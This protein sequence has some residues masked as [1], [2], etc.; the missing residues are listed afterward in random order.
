MAH[1]DDVIRGNVRKWVEAPVMYNGGMLDGKFCV[2]MGSSPRFDMYGCE[3]GWG[4]AVALRSGA[5]SKFEGKVSSYPGWE[6]GGSV[7]LEVCLSTEA[8]TAL[9]ADPE[10]LNVVSLNIN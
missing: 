2:L 6:G 5:A 7:D 1:T 4:K 3:F 9:E 8:M 10:F